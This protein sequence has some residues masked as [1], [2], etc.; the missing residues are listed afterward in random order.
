MTL[1]GALCEKTLNRIVERFDLREI[2]A[3]PIEKPPASASV[4]VLAGGPVHKLVTV[5]MAFPPAGLDSHMIFAFT[6]P[7][8]PVPHFTLDSV[9]AGEHHAFH[10][11][12]IPRIELAPNLAYM[13]EVYGALTPTL[14][15]G[16][17]HEGLSKANLSP[18]QLAL[19]SPWML[20]ARATEDAFAGIGALVDTYLDHWMDLC[21][22]GVSA[23]VTIDAERDAR[24]RAVLFDPDVDHVWGQVSQLLGDEW[25]ERI[26]L[27]LRDQ[28]Q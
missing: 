22:R 5:F 11:D 23:P 15:Q 6:A 7:D 27:E 16:Q 26:R 14:E 20:A 3:T 18:R 10:L 12:L 1:A 13:D 2:R 19:M 17:S 25:S 28:A 8:S 24:H 4:R 21:E 9:Q